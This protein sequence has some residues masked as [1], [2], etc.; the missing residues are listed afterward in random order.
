LFR[1]KKQSH[2]LFW[3]LEN[4]PL[5]NHFLIHLLIVVLFAA[6]CNLPLQDTGGSDRPAEGALEEFMRR[7][8]DDSGVVH[9]LGVGVKSARITISLNGSFLFSWTFV[10]KLFYKKP[11]PRA[12]SNLR[13][14]SCP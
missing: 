14:A 2:L 3:A 5:V 8:C 10:Q 7:D 1:K 4:F 13:E 6:V 9:I 11:V 12:E